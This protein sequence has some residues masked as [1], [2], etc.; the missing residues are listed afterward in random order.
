MA[1]QG[2]L[3]L[4]AEDAADL[5]IVSSAVQ[6]AVLQARNI[7]YDAKA[8]RF[9]LEVNRFRWEK[10]PATSRM[11]ALLAVEGVTH[12][13]TRAVS[14]ADPDMIYALLSV[15]FQPDET[16][17]GGMVNLVFAG[18]GEIEL[19]VEAL[20]VVLLDSGY[21]WPTRHRPDHDRKTR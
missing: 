12:V 3:R 21:E 16:P 19:T 4:V 15:G 7:R 18:D 9:S 1:D 17:P 2:G 14:N 5:D 13:R 20:E 10:A 8:R 11:R 6:D